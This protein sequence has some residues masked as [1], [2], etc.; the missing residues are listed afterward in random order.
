MLD[1]HILPHIGSM[2]AGEISKRDV[3]SLLD[4]VVAAPDARRKSAQGNQGTQ[5]KLTH[6]PNRLK[7]RHAG[8]ALPRPTLLVDDAHAGCVAPVEEGSL[9]T[10]R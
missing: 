3:I 8:A 9:C 1:R 5:R 4:A 10:R 6:R 7:S 2:K